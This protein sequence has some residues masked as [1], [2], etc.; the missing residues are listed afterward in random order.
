[1]T[2]FLNFFRPSKNEINLGFYDGNA[3]TQ[4]T[5]EPKLTL[6]TKGAVTFTSDRHI[7]EDSC[8]YSFTIFATMSQNVA[9][10]SGHAIPE[11]L[12]K[13]TH[14]K[15]CLH[16]APQYLGPHTENECLYL[17]MFHL[18]GDFAVQFKNQ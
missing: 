2:L 13:S 9:N 3:E 16:Q 8:Q 18:G 4:N 6:D 11:W 10:G 17:T 14:I 1:M 12:T 15:M 7:P 5:R